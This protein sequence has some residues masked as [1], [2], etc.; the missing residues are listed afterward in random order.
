MRGFLGFL[1]ISFFM[2]LAFIITFIPIMLV[3]N[4]IL[5]IMGEYTP[6]IA[7]LFKFLLIF[8]LVDI[9][10]SFF[11]ELIFGFIEASQGKLWPRYVHIALE[12]MITFF[13]ITIVDEAMTSVDLS[14][15][16]HFFIACSHALLGELV[17]S[18]KI[19]IL[20]NQDHKD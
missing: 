15:W 4:G 14:S 2:L 10:I 3:D 18:K 19:I 8:Y 5:F 9:I 1:T 11:A 17:N 12:T 6:G 13:V 7:T 20:P 16:T